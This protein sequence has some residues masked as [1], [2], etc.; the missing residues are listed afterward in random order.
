VGRQGRNARSKLLFPKMTHFLMHYSFLKTYGTSHPGF[1][2]PGHN[3]WPLKLV[4]QLYNLTAHRSPSTFSL[5][6]HTNTPVTG[7]H[8]NPDSLR[9][10]AL[11]TLRG[12]VKCSY[13]IHA[14]NAYASHLLPH[15][16]GA[17][18]IIP[19]RGQVIAL[20]ANVRPEKLTQASWGGSDEYW[21][22]RLLQA[23]EKHPLIILGG[24]R[25][26]T[27]GHDYYVTDDSVVRADTGKVLRTFL[28]RMFPG[29]FKKR[30]EPEMEWVRLQT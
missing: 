26:A 17:A 30:R 3:L 27:P 2:Y 21:F 25:E 6:L 18:G 4:T 11:S 9:R 12:S 19:T 14:T 13:V 15:M 16:Q 28:P 5:K 1:R 24:G 10:W 29:K 7:I 20:R 22:P 23:R 8:A